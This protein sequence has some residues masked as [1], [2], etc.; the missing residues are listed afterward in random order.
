MKAIFLAVILAGFLATGVRAQVFEYIRIEVIGADIVV[1]STAEE[2]RVVTW[3][4]EKGEQGIV[5]RSNV[6]LAKAVFGLIREY[7]QLGWEVFTV[8]DRP[9]VWIMRK[10]KQ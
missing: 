2:P 9:E 8:F 5:V 4:V 3:S 7:E 1:V 6:S 10:A